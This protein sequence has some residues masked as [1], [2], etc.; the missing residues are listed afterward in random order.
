LSVW[1]LV[2]SWGSY[3][4]HSSGSEARSKYL[5]L[6]RVDSERLDWLSDKNIVKFEVTELSPDRHRVSLYFDENII[7]GESHRQ[8]ID[9]AKSKCII[10]TTDKEES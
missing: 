5:D 2:S 3:I 9:I 8:C 7:E 10:S 1:F 4:F 6:L